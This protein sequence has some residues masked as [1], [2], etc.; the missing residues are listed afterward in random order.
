MDLV[1]IPANP[2]PDDVVTGTLTDLAT[3]VQ[4]CA[5]RAGIRRA[6]RKGTVCIIQ[7]RAEFIEKYFETVRETALA[8]L[9][10][11]DLRLARPRGTVA[12]QVRRSAKG[13]CRRPSPNT[14]RTSRTFMKE[15]VLPDCP[16]PI[17]A[18]AHSMGGTVMMRVA[19]QGGRWF[20]R[21]VLSAPMIQLA[22]SRKQRLCEVRGESDAICRHGLGLCAER[23]A[24]TVIIAT[25]PYIG[26]T[27]PPEPV[28][29][30]RTKAVLE[31]APDLGIGSPT[32][33][34][35]NARLPRHGRVH[36]SGL[37]EQGAAGR[38]CCWS[39]RPGDQI[40]STAAIEEHR[41]SG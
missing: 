8:R 22:G 17:F 39:R 4:T 35:L 14:S 18:V 15:V 12:A 23:P 19:R 40:V 16:P 32:V 20:D 29:Y 38:A 3:A 31:A 30:A 5:L 41:P 26:S 7:G 1:S 25:G 36:R 6:G 33:A 24:T 10:G 34:W 28:R 2:V 21:I 9:C 27:S 37:S 11:G 13:H